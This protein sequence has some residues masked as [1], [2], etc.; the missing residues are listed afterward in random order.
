MATEAH[1]QAVHAQPETHTVELDQVGEAAAQVHWLSTQSMC[2]DIP[3]VPTHPAATLPG[4]TLLEGGNMVIVALSQGLAH[5]TKRQGLGGLCQQ[6][7][8]PLTA[9]VHKLQR[10]VQ[11][12]HPITDSRGPGQGI[13]NIFT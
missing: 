12:I 8:S 10:L 1:L 5:R 6:P 11:V 7:L 13:S 2:A 3:E 4:L 9:R